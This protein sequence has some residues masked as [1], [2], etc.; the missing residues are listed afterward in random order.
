MQRV[1]ASLLTALSA[2]SFNRPLHSDGRPRRLSLAD[3]PREVPAG[4]RHGLMVSIAD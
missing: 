3:T 1:S 2:V 4:R